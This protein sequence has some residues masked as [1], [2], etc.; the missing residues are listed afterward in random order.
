MLRLAPAIRWL[1]TRSLSIFAA[2]VV[3]GTR[4]GGGRGGPIGS[5]FG[6]YILTIVVNILLVLNVSAYYSTIA[7]GLILL[8]AVLASSVSRGSTLAHQLRGA[9]AWLRAWGSGRLPRYLGG[10]D[11]RLSLQGIG[12]PVSRPAIASP[13]WIRHRE[14]LRYALPSYISLIAVVMVTRL[15]FGHAIFDWAYWNSVI[16]LSSFL[17]ILALGQGT[18]ILT[19][20]L[21]L[22][23][24]WTIG[25]CGIVLAGSVH[26]SDA[27]LAFALPTVL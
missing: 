16:V 6:A 11:R 7:E 21:D 3:G 8:L 18:V 27:A 12:S 1:A 26:G 15:W 5:I 19:G 17:A 14:A 10:G 23:V 20:G 22:S 25:F 13:F 9:V 4:L 24:P 2:V